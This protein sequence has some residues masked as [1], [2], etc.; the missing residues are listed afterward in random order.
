MGK[1]FV[2]NAAASNKENEDPDET[3]DWLHRNDSYQ[4]NKIIDESTRLSCN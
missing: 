1:Y 3:N 2:D 4:T